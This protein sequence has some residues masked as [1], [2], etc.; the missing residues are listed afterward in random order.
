MFGTLSEEVEA[1][2]A[3][4]KTWRFFSSL[5]LGNIV[6][7]HFL[8]KLEIVEGDGGVGTV[9]KLTYKPGMCL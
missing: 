9:L 3:P 2:V 4:S 1:K 8:D 6:A 7:K 5:E